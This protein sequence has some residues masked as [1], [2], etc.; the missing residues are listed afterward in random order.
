MSVSVII[1]A[2]GAG[3][4]MKSPLP[5][6]LHK[7]CGKEMLFFSIKEALKISDDIHIVVFHQYDKII[8]TTQKAFEDCLDKINFHLQ[9]YDCYPGTGGALMGASQTPFPTKYDKILILNGDMPLITQEELEK[10]LLPISP[11]T[12][13]VFTL[14]NPSGYGRVIVENQKVQ[15]IIEEKDACESIKTISTANAGVYA[16]HKSILETYLP[17]LHNDNAQKEFYLTDII[18]LASKDKIDI[19]PVFVDEKS[20]LGI[21]SKLHLS[22]A[23]DVMLERL[24]NQA[25]NQGV[26]IHLPHTVYLEADV[27]FEG[28]CHIQPGVCISGKSKIVNSV[29]KSH[30][31]IE[32]SLIENSDIGPMAH[33]RPGCQ[34]FNTH[35]GNFVEVKASK[36]TGV[37]AGH[38]SYLGDCQIDKGSNIGAGVITCNYDGKKKHKTII[39][40]N[41]FVGS[42]T[43]LIAPLNIQSNVLIASG[44]TM[45]KDAKEG[46]L[47][48]SRI[49]QENKSGGFYRFFNLFKK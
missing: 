20:F 28:Q 33:I 38:L 6:V 32:D 34:I 19:T 39:G 18:D 49:K 3:T 35:I 25:I 36:L 46:D 9:N 21:N 1:L 42:D 47:V 30:T 14:E 45:T 7:I 23:E 13:S 5:K 12:L 15:K 4:R 22:Q 41:V 48:V 24:R 43:Q 44:T 2:A 10:I 31:V 40:E 11:I 26:T 16:I 8:Q 27:V 37:K 17:K 29:I